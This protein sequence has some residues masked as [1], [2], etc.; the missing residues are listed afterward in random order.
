MT[1]LGWTPGG[2]NKDLFTFLLLHPLHVI[3]S[4]EELKSM[5]L[6]IEEESISTAKK[7]RALVKEQ[8]KI[9]KKEN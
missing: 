3:T 6:E 2:C 5:L 7:N 4:V 8:I 1:S 9:R